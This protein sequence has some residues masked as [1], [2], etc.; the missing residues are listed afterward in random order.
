MTRENV[1]SALSRFSKKPINFL[2]INGSGEKRYYFQNVKLD[3]PFF[4]A[5]PQKLLTCDPIPSNELRHLPLVPIFTVCAKFLKSKY[6]ECEI[7]TET[8]VT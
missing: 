8:L 6:L 5:T 1:E 4:S 3:K 7:W 2:I